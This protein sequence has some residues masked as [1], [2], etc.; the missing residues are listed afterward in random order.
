MGMA[1]GR[2]AIPIASLEDGKAVKMLSML[3]V[4]GI[5]A[6]AGSQTERSS[7]FRQRERNHA[8]Q[9]NQGNTK[10]EG[11][12]WTNRDRVVSLCPGNGV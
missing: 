3:T 7:D 1:N 2:T 5:S 10:Y 12:I 11:Q 4:C 9:T 6:R 8:W